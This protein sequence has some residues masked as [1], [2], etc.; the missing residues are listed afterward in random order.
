MLIENLEKIFTRKH[1]LKTSNVLGITTEYGMTLCGR[2]CDNF[3]YVI[4]I[5]SNRIFRCRYCKNIFDECQRIRIE[6]KFVI[7]DFNCVKELTFISYKLN[8]IV[9]N[10]AQFEKLISS[11]KNSY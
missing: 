6:T 8:K 7:Y 9:N 3:I 10:S 5:L 11:I 1:C 4:Y 2:L